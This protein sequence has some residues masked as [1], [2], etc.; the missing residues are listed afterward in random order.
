M[1]EKLA[2][3]LLVGIGILLTWTANIFEII[4]YASRAFA[5]YYAIQSSI[6]AI[7]A[8]RSGHSVR[9]VVF[10]LLALLGCAITV[11]GTPVA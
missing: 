3:A 8:W 1:S 6:A 5:L 2:Y 7:R 11:L 4:S 9:T 10:G